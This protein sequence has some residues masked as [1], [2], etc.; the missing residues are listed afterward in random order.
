[1]NDKEYFYYTMEQ[2]PITGH[3]RYFVTNKEMKK[4]KEINEDRRN[5]RIRKTNE[6]TINTLTDLLKEAKLAKL[7]PYLKVV[8][9]DNGNVVGKKECMDIPLF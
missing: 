6:V 4:L 1:M 9:K 2:D 5:P 7:T 3:R 8:V